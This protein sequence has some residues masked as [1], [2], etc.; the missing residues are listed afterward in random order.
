MHLIRQHHGVQRQHAGST[1]HRIFSDTYFSGADTSIYFGD[2]WVDEVTSIELSVQENVQ[3]IYGYAS[4]T[5]D[6]WARGTRLITGTFRI[7]FKESYYLHAIL[8]AIESRARTSQ[9]VFHDREGRVSANTIEDVLSA[10]TEV[11]STER[12]EHLANE[13]Q[14]SIWGKRIGD[15]QDPF[16]SRI[17]NQ[18]TD[19]YFYS[20]NRQPNLHKEGF[21]ILISYGPYIKG[22]D[23]IMDAHQQGKQTINH[24]I[25]SITGVQI[26]AMVKVIESHGQAIEEQYS[27]IAK[28]IN[29][30]IR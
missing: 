9:P 2:I 15:T 13:Y 27:F 19:A 10:T 4:Y 5:A 3:P 17:Q 14:Q 7:N 25:E 12:F 21:N 26:A 23:Q 30:K 11:K 16:A 20:R 22:H 1:E 24:T 28:D 6:A 8:N 29:Y 18:L